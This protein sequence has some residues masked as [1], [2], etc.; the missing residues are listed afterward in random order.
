V[1]IAC[2]SDAFQENKLTNQQRSDLQ[3]Y[4]E[5]MEEGINE[6]RKL[7]EIP[8]KGLDV[9]DLLQDPTSEVGDCE[10][11]VIEYLRY[12]FADDIY[13][14]D[15]GMIYAEDGQ[16]AMLP[17]FLL[18]IY[19]GSMKG[20]FEYTRLCGDRN[21][22]P[23]HLTKCF[24]SWRTEEILKYHLFGMVDQ[25]NRAART[26]IVSK[27]EQT[28]NP[29]ENL[30]L[31]RKDYGNNN[32]LNNFILR[33]PFEYNSH[34]RIKQRSDAKSKETVRN[35][36]DSMVEYFT[37][38]C[39]TT[40][41]KMAFLGKAADV[42][43]GDIFIYLLERL[44]END[45]IL[46]TDAALRSCILNLAMSEEKWGIALKMVATSSEEEQG[47]AQ[48]ASLIMKKRQAIE[49]KLQF[50]KALEDKLTQKAVIDKKD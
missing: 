49:M 30:K 6:A 17:P 10:N 38:L 22:F 35:V 14:E 4:K 47:M 16:S 46:K 3:Q 48:M 39:L 28:S 34:F 45:K 27:I 15:Q 32:L 24:P 37:A 40:E 1:L 29:L 9:L 13:G 8:K 33:Y 25:L 2:P 18:F 5:D 12:N 21:S 19:K 20:L 23:G 41:Q 31:L 11:K 44:I 42:F 36:G 7:G 50:L 26:G 43:K